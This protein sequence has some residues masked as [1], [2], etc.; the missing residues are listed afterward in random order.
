MLM[1][2]CIHANVFA[3]TLHPMLIIYNI[4]YNLWSDPRLLKLKYAIS[5]ASFQCFGPKLWSSLSKPLPNVQC[6]KS[7][8]E[9]LE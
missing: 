3:D 4:I 1:L 2:H 9:T 7:L 5:R 8:Y 6:V